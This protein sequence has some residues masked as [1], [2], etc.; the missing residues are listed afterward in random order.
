[1]PRRI[2]SHSE[3]YLE[4]ILSLARHNGGAH[5]SEVADR[6]GVTRASVTGALRSLARRGLVTYQPYQPVTLTA[7][8]RAVAQGVS[9]RRGA[10]RAFFR[11]QLGLADAEAVAASGMELASGAVL[12]RLAEFQRFLSQCR[13]IELA[14]NPDGTLQCLGDRIPGDCRDCGWSCSR[15]SD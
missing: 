14:W 1:M 9:D 11:D 6:V 8:G 10:L 15:I 4:A 7:E 2:S 12:D 13:R 5:A 3:V